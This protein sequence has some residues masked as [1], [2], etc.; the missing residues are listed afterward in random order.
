MKNRN[1]GKGLTLVTVRC[2][3]CGATNTVVKPLDDAIGEPVQGLREYVCPV[4]EL[5]GK[6]ERQGRGL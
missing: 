3:C 2:T 5:E 1:I 6:Q 4:C